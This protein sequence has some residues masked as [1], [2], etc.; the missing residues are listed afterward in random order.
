ML[1]ERCQLFADAYTNL[2]AKPLTAALADD[3]VLE[4]QMVLEPMMGKKTIA[5][6]LRGKLQTIKDAKTYVSCSVRRIISGP[7]VNA[8]GQP[9][10]VMMQGSQGAVV[11]L[12]LDDNGLIERIDL[13]VAPSP[14]DTVPWLDDDEREYKFTPFRSKP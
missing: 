8:L 3:C 13:C 1:K 7:V 11:L 9:C 14:A 6:Y 2:Q 5:G 10:V 12:N 4:S